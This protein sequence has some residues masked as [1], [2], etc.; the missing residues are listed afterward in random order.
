MNTQ[1]PDNTDRTNTHAH[2]QSGERWT[3]WL[4]VVVGGGGDSL[5]THLFRAHPA[6]W[7]TC[8]LQASCC[9]AMQ[10]AVSL[11]LLCTPTALRGAQELTSTALPLWLCFFLLPSGGYHLLCSGFSTQRPGW[12]V[13]SKSHQFHTTCVSVLYFLKTH[14]YHI[15]LVFSLCSSSNLCS[16]TTLSSA[17][18]VTSIPLPMWPCFKKGIPTVYTPQCWGFVHFA[19]ASLYKAHKSHINTIILPNAGFPHFTL[20]TTSKPWPLGE[21]HCKLHQ[22]QCA[23]TLLNSSQPYAP[24]LVFLALL[25][26]QPPG[27]VHWK[28]HQYWCACTLLSPWYNRIGWLLTHSNHTL[29]CQFSSLHSTSNHPRGAQNSAPILVC[30]YPPFFLNAHSNHILQCWFS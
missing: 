25:L 2:T 14:S 10:L 26:L 20:S 1:H 28:L 30:L 3:G 21:V 9:R 17:Q 8:A 6:P 5:Q 23:C 19:M 18:Q 24:T 13:H 7:H 29:Q 22:C 15:M 4:T 11:Q 12:K 27:G 16:L